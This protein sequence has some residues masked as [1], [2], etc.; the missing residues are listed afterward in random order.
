MI[1]HE[2]KEQIC[3]FYV[4]IWLHTF[5]HY[6]PASR[7]NIEM[8]FENKEL[9]AVLAMMSA[10]AHGYWASYFDSV[11]EGEVMTNSI[12]NNV[13]DSKKYLIPGYLSTT[14]KTLEKK[15]LSSN[16]YLGLDIFFSQLI[17]SMPDNDLKKSLYRIA[18]DSGLMVL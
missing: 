13:L 18:S 6:S 14:A 3:T 7:F 8:S 17:G 12:Y 15:L 5:F 4:C 16:N 11:R 2:Q 9:A 10:H 1:S